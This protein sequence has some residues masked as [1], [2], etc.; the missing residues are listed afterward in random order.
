MS[1]SIVSIISN[2]PINTDGFYIPPHH[3]IDRVLESNGVD[4]SSIGVGGTLT[5]VLVREAVIFRLPQELLDTICGFA[6]YRNNVWEGRGEWDYR[7]RQYTAYA[8]CVVCKRL[9][10]S[11]FQLL[12]QSFKLEN[13]HT[14]FDL[15]AT[16]MGTDRDPLM[17]HSSLRANPSLRQLCTDLYIVFRTKS[18]EMDEPDRFEPMN[19]LAQWLTNITRLKVDFCTPLESAETNLTRTALKCMRNLEELTLGGPLS[20]NV[21]VDIPN[22]A[23]LKTLALRN[24]GH[25]LNWED[26]S[27]K[28]LK[29]LHLSDIS[30]TEDALTSLI[31]CPKRLEHFTLSHDYVVP[32]PHYRMPTIQSA[33]SLHRDSLRTISLPMIAQIGLEDMDLSQFSKLESIHISASA[34]GHCTQK[35]AHSLFFGAQQTRTFILELWCRGPCSFHHL[36][37]AP[38]VDKIDWLG[39]FADIATPQNKHREIII[40]FKLDTAFRRTDAVQISQLGYLWERLGE[41]RQKLALKGIGLS[42][43]PPPM[44]KAGFETIM[45]G[46]TRNERF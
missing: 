12:Y 5:E 33:L 21:F 19:D 1:K 36:W 13:F 34:F 4:K 32:R 31:R 39:E 8:L 24:I 35:V 27:M 11:A 38:D 30:S 14:M 3:V 9:K 41:I 29:T 10:K 44:T 28:N 6:T 45:S 46:H 15:P 16:P 26:S 43:T 2:T 40:T 18:L 7:A 25:L 23:R 37:P 42:Y 20:T 17:F 22:L